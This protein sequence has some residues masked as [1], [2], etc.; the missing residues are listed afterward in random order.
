MDRL[1]FDTNILLDALA[2]RM[3]FFREALGTL[4][5]VERKEAAGA[6]CALSLS[7]I[8]YVLKTTK[9]SEKFTRFHE[10][11]RFLDVAPLGRIEVDRAL[12]RGVN[13]FE[14]ALQW[15][16]ARSWKATHLLTRNEADF[17]VSRSLKVLTPFAYME[18]FK[19]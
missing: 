15:E 17:P 1:F 19:D 4:A 8:D 14:D 9:T 6:F 18:R 10:L 12:K 11:R 5:I 2:I 16:S 7:T 3:P 13:D